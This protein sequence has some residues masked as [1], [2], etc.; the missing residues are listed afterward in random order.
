ML[1][2]SFADCVTC[3]V[4][5]RKAHGSFVKPEGCRPYYRPRWRREDAVEQEHRVVGG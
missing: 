4:K 3:G 2:M 5:S 1:K